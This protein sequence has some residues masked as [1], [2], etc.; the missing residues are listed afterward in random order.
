MKTKNNTTEYTAKQAR[1]ACFFEDNANKYTFVWKKGTE[2]AR[3]R[4]YQNIQTVLTQMK[5]EL[6]PFSVLVEIKEEYVPEEL[7]HI[8]NTYY[9]LMGLDRNKF[10]KGTGHRKSLQHRTY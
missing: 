2:K 7:E 8:L 1:F 9:A 3:Y 4:L 6:M 10:A 5:E